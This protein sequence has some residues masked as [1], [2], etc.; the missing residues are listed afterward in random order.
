MPA[1]MSSCRSSSH[2]PGAMR[3][4]VRSFMGPLV[5]RPNLSTIPGFRAGG[6]VIVVDIVELLG[7]DFP[8]LGKSVVVLEW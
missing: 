8:F 6:G 2:A 7:V 5:F 3:L 4:R 1:F